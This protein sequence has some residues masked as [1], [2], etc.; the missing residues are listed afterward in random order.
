M[1]NKDDVMKTAKV[2]ETVEAVGS[3]RK[4]LEGRRDALSCKADQLQARAAHLSRVI[5]A[6]QRRL[7]RRQ[8][9]HDKIVL[10]ALMVMVG[11]H[12]FQTSAT[13]EPI[14]VDTM[15]KKTSMTDETLS[16]DKD[17]LT[18]A[19]LS[20]SRQLNGNETTTIEQ[21]NRMRLEGAAF[22]QLSKI[23]KRRLLMFANPSNV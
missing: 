7:E 6:G 22:R 17:L 14:V 10:G 15:L 8:D 11:L 18:G 9:A 20:L 2:G 19:L 3:A 4:A 21:R 5:E 12:R 16:F 1:D 13:G 23:G